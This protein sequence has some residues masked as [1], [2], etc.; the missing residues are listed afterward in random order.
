MTGRSLFEMYRTLLLIAGLSY[1]SVRCTMSLMR[2][3]P[4]LRVD[5]RYMKLGRRY[6][7]LQLMRIRMRRFGPELLQIAVLTIALGVLLWLGPAMT[8]R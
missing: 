3:L 6:V 5:S 1:V 8:G 7:M 2:V 4:L